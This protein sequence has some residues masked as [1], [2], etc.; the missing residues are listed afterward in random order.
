[1]FLHR[2]FA[3][4]VLLLAS[5][6]F[7]PGHAAPLYKAAFLPIDDFSPVAINNAG[8][9]AGSVFLADGSSRV[10][11]YSGGA[12]QDL[13]L[14]EGAFSYASAINDAGAIT[15]RTTVNDEAHAFLYQN[16]A[17]VDI[18]ANT[19]A[20]GINAHGDVVGAR[21]TEEGTFGFVYSGGTFTQL[22]NLGTGRLGVAVD[23]NNGGDI[24][25][26]SYTNYDES[27][28]PL[29]P[30]LYRDG[31]LLDL[32]P[33]GDSID[34]AAVAINNAGHIAGEGKIGNDDHVFL[35]A[36]G[37][38]RDLGFFGGSN[39]GVVGFNDRGTL[40][41]NASTGAG[42]MLAFTNIGD[43]LID[44]NTLLDPALGWQVSFVY[45]NNDLGQ[46]VGY[47]CQGD[48]CGLVQLDLIDAVPEPGAMLLLAAGL[49]IMRGFM[50]RKPGNRARYRRKKTAGPGGHG[51]FVRS[52]RHQ[53]GRQLR[54]N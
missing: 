28:P 39:L 29:H 33:L 14:P 37:V 31:A 49:L 52:P 34:T 13:G 42:G 21:Y 46:I 5:A 23:I 24:A 51:G 4:L 20:W 36:D 50:R 10:V 1:M 3:A 22:P 38:I 45:A 6:M 40:I 15:G 43:V 7:A 35:Y 9:I 12:L 8:Q 44:L 27:P 25:G 18:G 32:G 54:G 17:L 41:G 11:L 30:Y 53:P 19:S 26:F 47:G 48:I 16:G 2:Y